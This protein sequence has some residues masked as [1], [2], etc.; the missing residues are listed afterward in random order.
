MIHVRD[1]NGGLD[2]L[3]K[4]GTSLRENGLEVLAA[5]PGLLGN[6][7]LNELALGGERDGTRAVD[8][9]GGL[10]G[11]GLIQGVS[12][13]VGEHCLFNTYVRAKGCYSIVSCLFYVFF[14][15]TMG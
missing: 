3:L 8:G 13:R 5:L 1:E 15:G 9:V 10:D 6:G 4:G 7:A 11:L 14:H 2:N 12:M